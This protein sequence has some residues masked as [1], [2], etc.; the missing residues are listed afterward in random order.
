M[1]NDVCS[2]NMQEHQ[3]ALKMIYKTTVKR[4]LSGPRQFQKILLKGLKR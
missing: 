4:T 1:V 2:R 3:R